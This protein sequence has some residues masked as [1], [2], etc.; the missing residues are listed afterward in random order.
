MTVHDLLD[1]VC[2]ID[3]VRF[4]VKGQ[5]EAVTCSVAAAD[6]VF[7]DVKIMDYDENDGVYGSE[8]TIETGNNCKRLF[9]LNVRISTLEDLKIAR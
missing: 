5:H 1:H 8:I 3:E 4:D 7:G 2:G 6:V 9:V